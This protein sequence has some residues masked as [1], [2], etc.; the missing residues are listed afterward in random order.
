MYVKGNIATEATL[1]QYFVIPLIDLQ[2]SFKTDR[3]LNW[4]SLTYMYANDEIMVLCYQFSFILHFN[5][6]YKKSNNV[7]STVL[8]QNVEAFLAIFAKLYYFES[9]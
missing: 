6:R 5:W 8:M 7:I 9:N 3:V 1:W 2:L 4:L